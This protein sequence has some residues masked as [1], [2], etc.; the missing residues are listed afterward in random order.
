MLGYL[1]PEEPGKIVAPADGWHDTGDVVSIDDEGY[2]AIRGRLKR[3]AKIGGETVSLTVVENCA[4][5]LWP[6]HAHAAICVPDG[7]K[8]E[9]IVLV[10][11]NPDAQRNDL[12]VW[13]RN[14]GVPEL[15]VPKRVISAEEIP[16]LGTG[17]TDYVSVARMAAE[18]ADNPPSSVGE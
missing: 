5:A 3:F 6:D 4:S 13:V 16:V 18:S 9:A 10:T 12:L 8:G 14:H 1:R 17:K 7:R 2:L 11:T 15:A